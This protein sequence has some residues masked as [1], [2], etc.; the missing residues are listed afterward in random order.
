MKRHDAI[1]EWRYIDYILMKMGEAA[2]C[3]QMIKQRGW[4]C[5][6]ALHFFPLER[7]DASQLSM[8]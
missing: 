3:G 2:L 5:L 4:L 7:M 6:L 8:L 1:V